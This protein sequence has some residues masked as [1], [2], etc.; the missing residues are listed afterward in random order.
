MRLARL[1]LLEDHHRRGLRLSEYN[2]LWR[3]G[4]D[5]N[6]TPNGSDL[7]GKIAPTELITATLYAITPGARR[8]QSAAIAAIENALLDI[9]RR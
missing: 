5:D 4:I 8:H 1:F 2:E 7:I 3:R 9:T 6:D